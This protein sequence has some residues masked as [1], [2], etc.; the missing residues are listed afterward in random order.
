LT[1]QPVTA[2]YTAEMDHDG[3]SYSIT[4]PGLAILKCQRCQAVVLPDNA[5]VKLS[6]ALRRQIGL[7][8]PAEIR[9]KRKE[10]GLSQQELA[11]ALQVAMETVS[12]WE[13]GAQMQQRS[14][15]GFLRAFFDLPSLR[16][17]L[18]GRQAK[19]AASLVA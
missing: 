8:T 9:Q 10:I 15:D 12:R 2:D 1:V 14:L 3:R 11:D 5:Y 4:V 7:L 13:T 16:E 6:D 18:K 17:Y 19:A